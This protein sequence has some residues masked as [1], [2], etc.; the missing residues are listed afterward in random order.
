[1]E[2]AKEFIMPKPCRVITERSAVIVAF[3][4]E[5][6]V[7]CNVV[8]YS[9]IASF[10]QLAEY[11]LSLCELNY[12]GCPSSGSSLDSAS[13][14][15]HLSLSMCTTTGAELSIHFS[16]PKSYRSL[17]ETW[18]TLAFSCG[19]SPH[20]GDLVLDVL[21]FKKVAAALDI[22]KWFKW[23]LFLWDHWDQILDHQLFFSGYFVLTCS[24]V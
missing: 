17:S 16:F 6:A 18:G 8:S 22:S 2:N 21:H 24:G 10:T 7:C 20:L 4:P 11:A 23:W 3:N 13:Q 14:P 19:W 5:S 15:H 9:V 1:M 12:C